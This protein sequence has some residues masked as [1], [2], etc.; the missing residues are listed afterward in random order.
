MRGPGSSSVPR[1]PPEVNLIPRSHETLAEPGG[2][3]VPELPLPSSRAAGHRGGRA[4]QRS[5]HW[6]CEPGWAPE[7]HTAAVLRSRAP[8]AGTGTSYRGRAPEL[9]NETVHRDRAPKPSTGA[10]HRSRSPEL[11]TG[12]ALRGRA[13]TEQPGGHRGKQKSRQLN[14]NR[15]PHPGAGPGSRC[16][17]PPC[18]PRSH[19]PLLSSAGVSAL[20]RR[21]SGPRPRCRRLRVEAEGPRTDSLGPAEAPSGPIGSSRG[22]FPGET[23]PGRMLGAEPSEEDPLFSGERRV[24][25]PGQEPVGP[26]RIRSPA[27]ARLLTTGVSGI[28]SSTSG[29]RWI[30]PQFVS[31][32]RP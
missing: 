15:S 26:W 6:S 16:R 27:R 21:C 3:A 22:F 1:S 29:P 7:P 25:G 4:G 17:R 31:T 30:R 28:G 11:P 2:A 5:G 12:P 20:R 24:P 9:R 23:S 10:L 14:T 32:A 8:G 18:S 13:L 19:V